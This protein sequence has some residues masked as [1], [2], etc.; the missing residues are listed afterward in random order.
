MPRSALLP[1]LLI[2]T[3]LPLAV[4]GCG[5]DK[6]SG[7]GSADGASGTSSTAVPEPGPGTG[8]SVAIKTFIFRPKPLTVKPG[9]RVT[10]TNYD[11]VKHSVT[12]GLRGKPLAGGF[13]ADVGPTDGRFQHVFTARGTYRYFCKY[14]PG[15]GMEGVVVV[16]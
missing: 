16:E 6:T 3:A 13:D 1:T 14:H 12:A 7:S 15:P 4:G 2:A 11:G 5:E 8:D 9:T 10:W